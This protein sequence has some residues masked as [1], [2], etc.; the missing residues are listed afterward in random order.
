M[1]ITD[2]TFELLHFTTQM[3]IRR[4]FCALNRRK[5]VYDEIQDHDRYGYGGR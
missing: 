2:E 3:T 4:F 1:Q 5:K